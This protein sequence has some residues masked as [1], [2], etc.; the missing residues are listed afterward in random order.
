MRKMQSVIRS[1][2]IGGASDSNTVVCRDGDMG[3]RNSVSVDMGIKE[4]DTVNCRDGDKG[5]R[6][7][8]N[9]D[10]GM[11]EVD[12]VSCRGDMGRRNVFVTRAVL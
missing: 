5:R 9:V 12:T 11:K 2:Q 1:G 10:M 8:V 7:S 4:V 3:R 6:N